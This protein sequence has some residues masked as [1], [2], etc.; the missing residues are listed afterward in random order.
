MSHRS[1]HYWLW[2][3]LFGVI[4]GGLTYLKAHHLDSESLWLLL[5]GVL[6]I[7]FGAKWLNSGKWSKAYD[8]V[9]GVIFALIGILGLLLFG[10]I[11]IPLPAS[12]IAS[13]ALVGLSLGLLPSLIHTWLGLTSL[14]HGARSA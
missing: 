6:G 2:F 7:V 4:A 3:L 14:S 12:L 5:S 1:A 11:H 9:I 10:G 8:L 13:N